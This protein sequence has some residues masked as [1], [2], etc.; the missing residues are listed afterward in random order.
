MAGVVGLYVSACG[1]AARPAPLRIRIRPKTLLVDASPQITIAGLR[2]G[3]TIRLTATTRRAMY[4][5]SGSATFRADAHGEVELAHQAPLD[6]AYDGTAALGLL[7]VQ[8]A[9]AA[10]SPQPGPTITTFHASAAGRS[11]TATL[12]QLGVTLMC[13]CV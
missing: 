11:A 5:W 9:G 10:V 7:G 12:R 4:V 2:P 13:E 8:K 3:Q 6:H 1:G